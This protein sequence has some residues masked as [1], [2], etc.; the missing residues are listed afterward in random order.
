MHAHSLTKNKP[1]EYNNSYIYLVDTHK[2]IYQ[3][4]TLQYITCKIRFVEIV[5]ILEQLFK[6]TYIKYALTLGFLS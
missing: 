3:F 5:I 2:Y 6:N 4:V 1:S